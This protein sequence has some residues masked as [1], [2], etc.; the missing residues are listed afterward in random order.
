[1]APTGVNVILKSVYLTSHG[2]TPGELQLLVGGVGFSSNV[3]LLKEA[4]VPEALTRWDGW[5]VLETG[6]SVYVVFQSGQVDYWG[7]GAELPVQ[8]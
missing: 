4:S 1:V 3:T 6:D 5:I 7:S 2:D 8:V